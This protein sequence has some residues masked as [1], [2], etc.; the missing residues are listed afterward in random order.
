MSLLTHPII[1][2]L[3]LPSKCAR[4]AKAKCQ[5]QSDRLLHFLSQRK[6]LIENN[7]LCLWTVRLHHM[8][9]TIK[10]YLHLPLLISVC[11][12]LN[13]WALADKAPLYCFRI[14]NIKKEYKGKSGKVKALKGKDKYLILFIWLNYEYPSLGNVQQENVNIMT[15][16]NQNQ[17]TKAKER[18]RIQVT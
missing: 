1:T 10:C 9:F 6:W 18:S 7:Y 11:G 5:S 3:N 12:F 16:Q 15:R 17:K 8:L 13:L 14:R 2:L 4:E